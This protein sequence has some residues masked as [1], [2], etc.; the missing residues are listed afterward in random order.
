M[1]V[2]AATLLCVYVPV[3]NESFLRVLFGVA[4]VLFVPGY[5]LI[6][7]LFPVRDDLMVNP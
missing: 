6:A 3:L 4:M 1:V 2:T 5:T 7:A